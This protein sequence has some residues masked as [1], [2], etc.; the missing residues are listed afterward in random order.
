MQGFFLIHKIYKGGG[1]NGTFKRT[2]NTST[3]TVPEK[4]LMVDL[5]SFKGIALKMFKE[6]KEDI[7]RVKK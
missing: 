6:L 4:D 7:E 2:K 1:G 5:P 3:G